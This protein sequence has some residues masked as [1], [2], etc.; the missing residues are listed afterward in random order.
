[1]PCQVED[2]SD[3]QIT[4]T[5]GNSSAGLKNVTVNIHGVGDSNSDLLFQ[6]TFNVTGSLTNIGG[7]GGGNNLTITGQGFSN[8]T[9]VFVCDKECEIV[10]SSTNKIVCI[11]PGSDVNK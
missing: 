1:M 6:Y 9:R 3:T 4:C 8:N 2:V 7:L 10:E 5:L 11:V